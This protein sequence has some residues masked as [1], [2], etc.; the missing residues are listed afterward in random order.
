[1]DTV[2]LK[3][4]TALQV[5]NSADAA[6]KK[7]LEE[8]LGVDFFKR[9]ITDIVKTFQG[10]CMVL[11]IDPYDADFATGTSDEIAYKKLKVIAKALNEGAELSYANADQKK[12]YP[13][14]EYSGSGF[15]FSASDYDYTFTGTTGGSRLCYKSEELARYAGNQFIELYNQLLK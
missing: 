9:K 12:W 7:T 11:N 5:Y 4:T 6:G 15:R 14:F 1:M 3:I 2:T 10:A 13:W 8:L